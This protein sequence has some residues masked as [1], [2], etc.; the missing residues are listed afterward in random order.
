MYTRYI[1]N[2]TSFLTLH[3][4]YLVLLNAQFE[5]HTYMFYNKKYICI[6]FAD[7]YTAFSNTRKKEK[8]KTKREK[9]KR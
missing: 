5:V 6:N 7:I 8:R 9:K 2:N 1:N 4:H 3:T